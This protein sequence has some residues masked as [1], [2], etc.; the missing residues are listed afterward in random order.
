MKKIFAG[1]IFILCCRFQ[2]LKSQPIANRPAKN[3]ATVPIPTGPNVLGV[4]DGRSPC[5][6]IA[7]E[8]HVETIPECTKIKWRLTLYQD[9]ITHAPTEYKLEGFVYRNPPRKGKWRIVRG[10]KTNPNAVVIQLDPDDP[11]KNIFLLKV[12]QYVLFFLDKDRRLMVGNENFS[13]TLYR[14]EN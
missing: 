4:F 2:Q 13:Y 8:L 12:D 7:R 6:G 14:T 11:G 9:S 5:Q 1:L 3:T 10:T